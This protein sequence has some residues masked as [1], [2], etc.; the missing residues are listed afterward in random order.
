MS[1]G[2]VVII[3]G[4]CGGG[5]TA[6]P[7]ASPN[8]AALP[9]RLPVV[10]SG[11]VPD[12]PLS[13]QSSTPPLPE[14]QPAAATPAAPAA[15]AS[16]GPGP[17]PASLL[18]DGPARQA[19]LKVIFRGDEFDPKRIEIEMGQAV[20]FVNE[21]NDNLW[22]ASNLEPTHEIHPQFDAGAPVL[23]GG[24][25][26]LAFEKAGFWRYHN[27][28]DPSQSGLVVVTGDGA[29]LLRCPLVLGSDVPSF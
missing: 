9:Q 4:A 19:I 28:L 1:F 18:T 15:T 23:P 14:T 11:K 16:P 12:G 24:A 8:A 29:R 2:V 27:H 26:E 22:P 20:R 25:W 21:S 7:A 17:T 13:T 10:S 3:A 5:S 6:E